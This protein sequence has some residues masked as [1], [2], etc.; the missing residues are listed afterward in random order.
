MVVIK[1]YISEKRIKL[2]VKAIAKNVAKDF[3]KEVNLIIV[4]KGAKPFAL[5]LKNELEKSGKKVNS[6]YIKVKSYSGT[7]TTGK[8]K[9][10]RDIKKSL[11][12][13]DVL[14]VE[15]ILDTGLTLRFLKKYLSSAKKVKSIKIAVLLDKPLGRKVKIKA[16]YVGFRIANLFVVGFGLDFNEKFRELKY[17]GILR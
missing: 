16:D 14:I 9:V 4:L 8:I 2:K 17:V 7:K 5:A 10:K 1:R 11:N 6:Y 12:G 13:K 15:D 3:D